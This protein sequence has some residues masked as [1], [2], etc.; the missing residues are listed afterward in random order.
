MA[1]DG[2]KVPVSSPFFGSPQD[3]PFFV[4]RQFPCWAPSLLAAVVSPRPCSLR[5]FRGSLLSFA[6]LAGLL[7]Q[8]STYD[9]RFT[10]VD[11]QATSTVHLTIC[12]CQFS[13]SLNGWAFLSQTI[14]FTILLESQTL[15]HLQTSGTTA[16]FPLGRLT[17]VLSALPTSPWSNCPRNRLHLYPPALS[18]RLQSGWCCFIRCFHN[19]CFRGKYSH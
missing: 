11:W 9:H 10:F 18:G 3:S 7:P 14:W 2:S 5:G 8:L 13:P 17:C 1:G 12:S 4:L 6:V 19:C 16:A 15:Q